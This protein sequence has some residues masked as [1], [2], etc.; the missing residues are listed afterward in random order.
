[1]QQTIKN[2][3]LWNYG[4]TSWQYDVLCALILAFIFLT[5]PNWFSNGKERAPL[6]N[7][8][9]TRLI[10]SADNFSPAADEATKLQL[11]RKLT[12]NKNANIVGWREKKDA[13]GRLTAYEVDVR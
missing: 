8:P 13:D 9:V 3:V 11:V 4:R 5:P 6:E 2:V 7:A 10:V 1:M 12:G